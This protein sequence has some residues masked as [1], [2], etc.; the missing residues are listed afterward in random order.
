MFK[1]K[2]KITSFFL[3]VSFCYCAQA[4]EDT[5][6]QEER[7]QI[8]KYLEASYWGAVRGIGALP[9]EHPL[10]CAKTCYQSN[11]NLRSP[12]AAL[13][14][15]YQRKGV[16]GFYSGAVPNGA[17]MALKQA[18]R[19]P[20]M[21]FMP[22]LYKKIIPEEKEHMSQLATGLTIA[23]FE[24]FVICPLERL[25]VWL[26]TS[27]TKNESILRFFSNNK[28]HITRSLFRGLLPT[29][30]KQMTSWSTF[31]YSRS[32][33]KDI[34]K[35][36]HQS[37]DLPYTTL[38]TIAVGTG[39]VNTLAILPLDCIKTRMQ[40][41]NIQEGMLNIAKKIYQKNGL[42][43]F[44]AGWQFRIIQYFTHAFITVNILEQLEKKLKN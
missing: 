27:Q 33:F 1:I 20:L 37:D 23:N 13:K 30:A 12:V 4:M 10:D 11:P 39:T 31:L 24:T 14:D 15:I 3:F 36:Y 40:Q 28:G 9:L 38:L 21:I 19:W 35:R 34:A 18:Y 42:R 17:R 26:M 22:E 25:K 41:K 8:S 16:T 32:I 5:S 7:S 6:P 2:K 29:Y 43:G 44:Y